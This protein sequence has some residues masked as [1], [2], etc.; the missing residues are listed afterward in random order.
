MRVL[1]SPGSSAF[2]I[3]DV[4]AFMKNRFN[5]IIN[6]NFKAGES[7][8][9]YVVNPSEQPFNYFNDTVRAPL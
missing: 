8:L 5:F 2:R 4:F 9:K 1:Y 6:Y 3:K 7:V